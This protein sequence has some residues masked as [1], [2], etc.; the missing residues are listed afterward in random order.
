TPEGKSATDIALESWGS[1]FEE[2]FK[3]FT[4]WN[5]FTGGR[6]RPDQFYEEG[7]F[8]PLVKVEPIQRHNEYPVPETHPPKFPEN[9]AFNFVIF[10]PLDSVG[11]LEIDFDGQDDGEWR[12]SV[13][14]FLGTDFYPLIFETHLDTLQ[15]G[16]SQI[17]NWSDYQEIVLI[18]AATVSATG[19]YKYSYSAGYDSSLYGEQPFDPWITI[20][21][22]GLAKTAFVDE[23]LIFQVKVTDQNYTDTLTIEKTG[24]DVGDFKYTPGC[25]P[26]VGTF[27]WTPTVA[28]TLDSPY[29]VIFA[30]DDGHGGTDTM[31]VKIS[32]ETKPHQDVIGQNFPNPFVVND[33]DSTFFPFALS[34]NTTVDIWIFSIAGEL[35]RKIPS[36]KQYKYGRYDVKKKHELPFWDGKNDD[37]GYVSSGIYLYRVKTKNTDVIKKM[38]VIR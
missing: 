26:V 16:K 1:N 29:L 2:V 32:V 28:D 22:G 24:N 31:A 15:K 4:V 9:L 23:T 19:G 35:V 18:P 36:R 7:A 33:H 30:A 3:E 12:L 37:G 20:I 38:A 13:V 27:S 14:G 21:P 8:F 6:K 5:Y 10:T 25:S 17:Y 34:S 11:G